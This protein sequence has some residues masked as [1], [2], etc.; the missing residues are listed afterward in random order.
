[1]TGKGFRPNVHDLGRW[2]F[3]ALGYN[4]AFILVAVVLPIFCL[5]VVSLHPVWQGRRSFLLT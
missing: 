3:A 1:M 2:K 5:V 4:V